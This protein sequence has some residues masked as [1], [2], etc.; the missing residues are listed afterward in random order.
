MKA[1]VLEV[2]AR[3]NESG[4]LVLPKQLREALEVLPGEEIIF[5]SD[6]ET[7]RM[8]TQKQRALRAQAYIRSLIPSGVSLVDELIA[9]RR[10]E[11]RKEV[12]E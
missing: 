2:R 9:E 6:G 5:S 12:A 8:E 11:F 7:V 10:E 3:I 1:A 4:R